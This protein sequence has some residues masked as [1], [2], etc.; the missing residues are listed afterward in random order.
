MQSYTQ[1][2]DPKLTL[3]GLAKLRKRL[4]LP[5][6]WRYRSRT[7]KGDLVL[8]AAG[9][10]TVLQ[11]E[12]QNTYQLATTTRPAGKRVRRRV[13]LKGTTRTI[14]AS[15]GVV[16]DRGVLA[17]NPFGSGSL[18]LFG[19]FGD[20]VLDATFRLLFDD[21]SVIGTAA[22]PYTTTAS[23]IDFLGT[24]RFTGGTGAYRGISGEGLKV[25]DH[26]TLDGQNGTISVKGY[27]TH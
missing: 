6:G 11:D 9:T 24:A 21:G 5:D 20:G 8:S 13:T 2:K 19:T 16:E 27:A 23:E 17:G 18:R 14:G 12:L 25:H 4:A 22:L 15:G 3:A 7:L 10:A 26:N 1:I